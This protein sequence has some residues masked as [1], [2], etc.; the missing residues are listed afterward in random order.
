[1]GFFKPKNKVA[2]LI[3]EKTVAENYFEDCYFIVDKTVDSIFKVKHSNSP[4]RI[5][6][7]IYKKIDVLVDNFFETEISAFIAG[8]KRFPLREFTIFKI[9]IPIEQINLGTAFDWRSRQ[10]LEVARPDTK[11][12]ESFKTVSINASYKDYLVSQ[13]YERL[14]LNQ[15]ITFVK[16]TRLMHTIPENFEDSS[17]LFT[18]SV[19]KKK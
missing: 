17:K 2:P 6:N 14:L 18:Q 12:F 16:R 9:N 19:N 10:V 15:Q 3:V 4:F 8:K 1:M 5:D 11:Y 7:G 13:G